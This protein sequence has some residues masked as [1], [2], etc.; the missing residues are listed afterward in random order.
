MV[1]FAFA[2]AILAILLAIFHVLATDYLGAESLRVSL[3]ARPPRK[4]IAQGADKPIVSSNRDVPRNTTDL[5]ST[6]FWSRLAWRR[7][8]SGIFLTDPK[9]LL[10]LILIYIVLIMG[11]SIALLINLPAD[12]PATAFFIAYGVAT[13][14]DPLD[15][16][17]TVLQEHHILLSWLLFIH[18]LSWLWIPLIAATAVDAVNRI[19]EERKGKAQRALKHMLKERG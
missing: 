16:R 5:R 7:L 4:P 15:Y 9:A 11:T 10:Q 14:S 8:K 17:E 13:G 3:P 6:P 1:A 19:N 2:L 18:L 12:D